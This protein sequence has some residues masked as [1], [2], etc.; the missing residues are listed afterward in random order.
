MNNIV[1]GI[2][3]GI[4]SG[5]ITSGIVYALT[6]KFIWN[7]SVPLWIWVAITVGI[8][9]VIYITRIIIRE[10]RVYNLISEFTEGRFGDSYE[11]TWKFKRSKYGAYRSY[12]YEATEIRL[13]KPLAEMNNEKVHTLGHEVPE[14]TIKMILQLWLMGSMNKKMGER[15]KPVLEYLHWVE[16]SQYHNL[17]H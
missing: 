15:L 16:N 17:L 14:E 8:V 1:K 4:I 5:L 11:Y 10:Y 6:E 3:I 12:G 9:F 2:I 7:V 13:K